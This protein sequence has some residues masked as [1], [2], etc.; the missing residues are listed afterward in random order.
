MA[1]PRASGDRTLF[2][3]MHEVIRVPIA[4]SEPQHVA[5][6]ANDATRVRLAEASRRLDQ[7]VKHGLQIECRTTDDLKHIGGRSC[8]SASRSS[9]SSRVFSMAMSV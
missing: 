5:V 6:R 2:H 1:E 8:C 3:E 9:L 4:R 7:R